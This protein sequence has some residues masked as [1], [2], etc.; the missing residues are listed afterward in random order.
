MTAEFTRFALFEN[1]LAKPSP[2]LHTGL[3][4]FGE[5]SQ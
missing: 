1:A 3:Q 2:I 4:V 5:T